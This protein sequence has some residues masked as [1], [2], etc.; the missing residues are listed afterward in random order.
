MTKKKPQSTF[1]ERLRAARISAGLTQMQLAAKIGIKQPTYAG[2]E[3]GKHRPD[4]AIETALRTIERFA[5]TLGMETEELWPV[6]ISAK[7]KK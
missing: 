4:A 2:Y 7:G 5:D 3:T 6:A 1:A